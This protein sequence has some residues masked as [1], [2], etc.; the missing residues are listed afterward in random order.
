[1]FIEL[2]DTGLD[3]LKTDPQKV[4]HKAPEATGEF[5]GYKFADKILKPKYVIDKNPRNIEER[6]IPPGKR[7]KI[8]N[9]LRQVL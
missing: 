9:K 5:I 4:A 8:L 3:V 2:L 1:M 6:I 7:E